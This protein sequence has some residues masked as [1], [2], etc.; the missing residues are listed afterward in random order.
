MAGMQLRTLVVVSGG[1]AAVVVLLL[2]L[3]RSWPGCPHLLLLPW[4]LLAAACCLWLL[5]LP[6]G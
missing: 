5:L 1:E 2:G 3:R 6:C 4:Q